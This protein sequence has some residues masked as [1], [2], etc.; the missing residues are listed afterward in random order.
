[1]ILL[2][3]R[4]GAI[5]MSMHLFISLFCLKVQAFT[6]D[7]LVGKLSISLINAI[8]STN[9]TLMKQKFLCK[10]ITHYTLQV[11]SCALRGAGTPCTRGRCPAKVASHSQCHPAGFPTLHPSKRATLDP[12]IRHDKAGAAQLLSRSAYR[13]PLRQGSR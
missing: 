5:F 8:Y 11:K 4:L 2:Y 12:V 9:E 7:L 3:Q 13:L 6:P 1:M 10:S